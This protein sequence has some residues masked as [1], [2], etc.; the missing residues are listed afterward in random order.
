MRTYVTLKQH[1]RK[2]LRLPSDSTETQNALQ[3][4]Q[5]SIFGPLMPTAAETRHLPKCWGLPADCNATR[6]RYSILAEPHENV[7]GDY[8]VHPSDSRLAKIPMARG[9]DRSAACLCAIAKG[10]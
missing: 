5:W 1:S 9:S 3:R 2:G 8:A 4:S 6:R 10:D 7:C